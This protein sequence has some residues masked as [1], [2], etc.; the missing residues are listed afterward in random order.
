[1]ASYQADK[2]KI[3]SRLKRIEGQLRGIQRMIKDDK[4]CV[5]VLVQI[6]SVLGATQR[7]GFMILDDHIKGCLKNAISSGEGGDESI[8]ELIDVVQRFIKT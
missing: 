1:M 6:S 3:L 2:E 8:Q 7:V 5:D 4:Y